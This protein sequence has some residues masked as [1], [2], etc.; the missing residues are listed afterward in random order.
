MRR[1]IS[2]KPKTD[3]E[4]VDVDATVI[5]G[6][7]VRI[8]RGDLASPSKEGPW[9]AGLLAE[10][11][12][13]EVSR[14]HKRSKFGRT[15]GPNKSSGRG[16]FVLR[17]K[18]MQNRGVETPQVQGLGSGRNPR[19]QPMG[20][21]NTSATKATPPPDTTLL[22]EEVYIVESPHIDG[23]GSSVVGIPRVGEKLHKAFSITGPYRE[24]PAD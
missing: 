21:S 17:V 5:S 12:E 1:P 23:M 3:P 9:Q 10:P 11:G 20:A 18:Q 2:L 6:K 16:A 4:D 13:R 14:G 22:M 7:G 15:E 8:T 19:G 24:P